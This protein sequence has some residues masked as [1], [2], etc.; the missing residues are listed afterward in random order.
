MN[1]DI[2][3]KWKRKR[4]SGLFPNYRMGPNAKL[5]QEKAED[6]QPDPPAIKD[7]TTDEYM[8]R[9]NRR[10]RSYLDTHRR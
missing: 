10:N 3:R 6:P 8:S 9:I 4:K 2:Q 1:D 5:D 7:E